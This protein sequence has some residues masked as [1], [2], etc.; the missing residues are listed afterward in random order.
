MNELQFDLT[1]VAGIAGA[2]LFALLVAWCTVV[3]WV[4]MA[5]FGHAPKGENPLWDPGTGKPL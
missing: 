5:I 4:K 2:I 3:R 1:T